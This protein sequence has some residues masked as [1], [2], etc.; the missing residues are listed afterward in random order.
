MHKVV[1]L[2]GCFL[3]QHCFAAEVTWLK[4]DWPPHQITS[5]LYQDQGTFDVL[6]K[7]VVASL[8]HLRHQMKVVN[9]PRLEQAFLQHNTSVCS[10]GSLFTEKRAQSRWY[11]KAVAVLPGLAVH[12]RQNTDLKQHAAMQ[13]NGSMDVGKLAQDK[14]LTGAYQP[15]RFY[16]ASVMEATQTAN[17]IPQEFTSQLNAASLLISKRVDYVVEYPE[18]MAFYL[19]QDPQQQQIQSLMLSD[20]PPFVVS[21]ITCSKNPQ[22]QQ[23]INEINKALVQLWQQPEHK[24][25]LFRWVDDKTKRRLEQAYAQVQ[26]QVLGEVVQE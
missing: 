25:A 1:I 6:Q 11:S 12:F 22:G 3:C 23:L 26:Q 24:A 18:R 13:K 9:L 21:Y 15:N 10:F 17:F 7:L 20:A 4:T 16:P 8:P 14:S 2:A 19:E 5:G